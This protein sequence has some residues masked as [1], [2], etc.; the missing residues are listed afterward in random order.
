[1]NNI[2]RV[3]ELEAKQAEDKLK[4]KLAKSKRENQQNLINTQIS[5]IMAQNTQII[6]A[7]FFG[8]SIL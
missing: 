8:K 6:M 4:H 3:I 5:L 7:A 2:Q 1:M